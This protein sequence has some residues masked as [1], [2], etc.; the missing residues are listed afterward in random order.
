MD[1]KALL[2]HLKDWAWLHIA[3]IVTAV[4]ANLVGVI[5]HI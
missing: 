5:F 4:V 3:Y 2:Q 1:W